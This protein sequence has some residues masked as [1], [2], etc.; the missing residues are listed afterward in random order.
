M[1]RAIALL[2]GVIAYVVFLGTFVYAIGFVG[3]LVVGKSI[4][5]G[6]PAPFA[7]ALLINAALLG[8]FAV[9]HSVMARQGFKD[10]W[11]KLAPKSVE[12]STYVL[13]SSLVLILLYW[14]WR[15]MPGVVW[16]VDAS[17]AAALLNG[18]FWAGWLIVLLSTFLIDHFDLFGLRQVY[19][20]F[21]GREYSAVRFK[22]PV[23]YRLVRHPL[24]LGFII[25]FWATPHMTVGHLVFAVAT[26]AYMLI[27]IQLEERDLVRAFG[28]TYREYRREVA[29]IVPWLKIR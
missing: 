13:F 11:T 20:N 5:S 16:S 19:L 18:I 4:D 2:Y 1:G 14:Q 9:Q 29:M 6:T 22:T 26:T 24:L 23:F 21:V 25:A 12:R 15:P 17:W 27:G 8:L 7:R 3:N 10:W 28:D